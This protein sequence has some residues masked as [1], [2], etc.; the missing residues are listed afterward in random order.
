VC[1]GRGCCSDACISIEGSTAHV[2]IYNATSNSW[3]RF[4]E[5]LGQSRYAL[6]ATS[7]LSGLVF[8]A[9]GS[10]GSRNCIYALFLRRVGFV[11]AVSCIFFACYS[12]YVIKLDQSH[13]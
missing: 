4:P 6:A 3:F 5:G 13:C 10:K 8:F 9:G 11:K 12:Y 7:L 2:D 1:I